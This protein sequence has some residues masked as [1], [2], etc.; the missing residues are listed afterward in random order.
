MISH[1]DHVTIVVNDVDKAKEFFNLPGF[2]E[3]IFVQI[4]G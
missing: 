3:D 4:S 1:F 2:E